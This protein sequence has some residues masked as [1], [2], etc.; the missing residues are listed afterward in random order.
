MA[1][2][3][4]NSIAEPVVIVQSDGCIDYIN[5]AAR[6]LLAAE[7]HDTLLDSSILEYVVSTGD[8]RLRNQFERIIQGETKAIGLTLEMMTSKGDGRNLVVLNTAVQ[9]EGEERIKMLFFDTEKALPTGLPAEMIGASPVGITIAD[10]TRSD[11]PLIFVN[12]EFCDL[13]GYKREESLGRNCRF[14]QGKETDEET[15]VRIREAINAEEP[16]TVELRNYRKDDSMFWNRLTITPVE[17]SDGKVTHFL[18]FQENVT[19]RKLFEQEKTIFEMQAEA[20]EQAII[21]TDPEGTIEY[22]N[23]AFERTTGYT[24]EE[25]IGENPRLLKSEK[26]NEAFFAELWETITAGEIWEAELT[27]RRKSGELY[28]VRQ[29]IVPVTDSDGEIAQFVAIEEDITDEQ[30]IEQVLHVMD[31]V[32]RH[33]VRNSVT[34]IDGY[35]T[36]LEQGLD[37]EEHRAAVQTIRDHAEKLGKLSDETRNIRELIH[38]RNAQHSLS[39]ETIDGF[40][41]N[42]RELHPEA[43]FELTMDVDQDTIVQNGSLLQL[44]ID[45]ALE[46]AV[47]HN[48]Q[49]EP[50]V[51]ITVEE[52]ESKAELCIEI[53]DNGPGIPDEEWDVIQA[54]KE[55]QLE[56]CTGLGLWLIYWTVTALGGTM[57]RESNEPRGTILRYSIPLTPDERAPRNIT[58]RP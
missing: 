41:K 48:D 23:P 52:I 7:S 32:L 21:I 5:T 12:D 25:A 53:E 58:Y 1:G 42:R 57:D 18:G 6:L 45:E 19:E 14:L 10:A 16:V 39:V 50:N 27:N 13:T 28:Q 46:N 56:H 15:V 37:S 44:A 11:L 9:W 34:A 55:T 54:G 8:N 51:E 17:D 24:A 33:N 31:R 3:Q 2:Q 43:V 4:P 26:Q 47:I 30:F 35:A 38:R 49:D 22:V 20:I 29:K 40:V 36:M